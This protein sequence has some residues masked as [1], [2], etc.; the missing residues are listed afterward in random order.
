MCPFRMRRGAVR[1]IVPQQNYGNICK[2]T[3]GSHWGTSASDEP[4]WGSSCAD[5]AWGRAG[6]EGAA[7]PAPVDLW[8]SPARDAEPRRSGFVIS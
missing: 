2:E 6:E 3:R 1:Q 8:L 5:G 4:N 7:V